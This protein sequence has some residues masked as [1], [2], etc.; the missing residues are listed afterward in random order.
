[1]FR[2]ESCPHDKGGSSISVTCN[3][4]PASPAQVENLINSFNGLMD[5]CEGEEGDDIE[6]APKKTG[7]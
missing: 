6:D 7:K 1:M 4:S 2:F 3:G 5:C